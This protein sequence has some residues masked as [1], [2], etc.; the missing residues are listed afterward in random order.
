MFVSV[1]ISEGLRVQHWWQLRTDGEYNHSSLEAWLRSPQGQATLNVPPDDIW[2]Y[3]DE[4]V[5][6]HLNDDIMKPY[7]LWN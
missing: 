7:L 6:A 4:Q 2:V 1:V 5:H 3:H